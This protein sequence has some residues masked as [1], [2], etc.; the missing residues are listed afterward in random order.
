MHKN[1]C[2]Q[3]EISPT[4]G[5]M[6]TNIMH[7]KDS[8]MLG[9]AVSSR[10]LKSAKSMEKQFEHLLGHL[11]RLNEKVKENGL[12]FFWANWSR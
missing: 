2:V 1:H 5:V 11:E 3:F 7:T 12:A 6:V 9:T 4:T 8:N 10:N